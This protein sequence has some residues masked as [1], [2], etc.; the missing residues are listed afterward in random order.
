MKPS[1]YEGFILS[2]YGIKV[3]VINED[4]KWFIMVYNHFSL[5]TLIKKVKR[6]FDFTVLHKFEENK[7]LLILDRFNESRSTSLLS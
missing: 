2:E 3:D 5:F 1:K 7:F 6:N 4:D